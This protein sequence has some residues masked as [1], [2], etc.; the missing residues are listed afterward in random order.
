MDICAA[1]LILCRYGL[2]CLEGDCSL[3]PVEIPA[4]DLASIGGAAL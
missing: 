3:P 4:Y 2:P 1:S